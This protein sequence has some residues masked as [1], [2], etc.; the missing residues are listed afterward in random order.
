MVDTV[1]AI[2]FFL[3][4]GLD[5]E[6]NKKISWALFGHFLE[7]NIQFFSLFSMR[8]M[9]LWLALAWYAPNMLYVYI[10]VLW[11]KAVAPIV[12]VDS[13]FFENVYV[14][15]IVL[16]AFHLWIDDTFISS[17]INIPLSFNSIILL[18]FLKSISKI[19][20]MCLKLKN[21]ITN[22]WH[23]YQYVMV[24]V[25]LMIHDT[26]LSLKDT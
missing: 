25:V 23:W 19:C 16:I 21:T 8:L 9:C 6:A 26:S 1:P 22:M 4:G 18:T 10:Y 2:V 14:V 17:H 7:N 5:R 13:T 24:L 11:G 20:D 12:L 3:G 15:P